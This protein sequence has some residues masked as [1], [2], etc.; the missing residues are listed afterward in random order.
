MCFSWCLLNISHL[1]MHGEYNV[2][3]VVHFLREFDEYLTLK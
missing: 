2:K 3:V 1:K